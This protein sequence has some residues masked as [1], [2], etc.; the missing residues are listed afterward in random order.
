A[1]GPLP[2]AAHGKSTEEIFGEVVARA[3]DLGVTTFDMAPL[4][5]DGFSET[6]VAK[7]VGSRR[8]GMVYVTRAGAAWKRGRAVTR[9]EAYDLIS[10]CES[11]LR[12]L[13]TDRI[14]LWLL[15]NPPEHVLSRDDWMRTAVRLKEDGK[16]RF[17]GVSVGDD[18]AAKQV[19]EAGADAVCMA[20]SA[21]NAEDLHVVANEAKQK[22]VGVLARSPL[23]Y[24]L[25]AGKWQEGKTFG[26]EDHR[27][28]RWSGHALRTRLRQVSNLKFLVHGDVTNMTSAALRYVLANKLVSTAIVGARSTAQIEEAVTGAGTEPFLPPADLAKIPEA[29]VS[30]ER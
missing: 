26:T 9:F 3:L 25:L 20:Y 17:W 24:G 5:G 13:D 1:Y 10:D 4:W 11:S 29:I 23:A 15:H 18:R 27:A 22:G 6:A 30:A 21:L 16:I 7:A 19:I 14:D 28:Q 2:D 12:R 8:D